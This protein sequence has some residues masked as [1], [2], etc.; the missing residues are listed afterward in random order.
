MCSG[1]DYGAV[2]SATISKGDKRAADHNLLKKE[3]IR[4][5]KEYLSDDGIRDYGEGGATGGVL[6]LLQKSR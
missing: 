6:T 1:S 4:R 2:E 5:K 3:P